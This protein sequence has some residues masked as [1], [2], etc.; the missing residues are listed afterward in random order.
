MVLGQV[1][2]V[3]SEATPSL[4]RSCSVLVVAIFIQPTPLEANDETKRP[5]QV[6]VNM[7]TFFF[8]VGRRLKSYPPFKCTDFVKCVREFINNPVQTI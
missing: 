7:Q 2:L 5:Q 3:A 8:N 4:Q 1:I 6:Q